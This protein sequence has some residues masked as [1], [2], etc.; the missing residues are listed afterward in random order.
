MVIITSMRRKAA[1]GGHNIGDKIDQSVTVL[2]VKLLNM[3]FRYFF[4]GRTE[5]L[6]LFNIYLAIYPLFYDNG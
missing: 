4:A 2:L 1:F 6:F 5:I 3:C